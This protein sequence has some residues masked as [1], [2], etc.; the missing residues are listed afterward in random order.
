MRR[1]RCFPDSI[2]KQ[3]I[4]EDDDGTSTTAVIPAKAGIQ[5][6]ASSRFHRRRL[7]I[8]DR[9]LSRTM[10]NACILATAFARVLQ[11]YSPQKRGRSATLKGGRRE[12]RVR[13]APAVSCA[14]RRIKKRTRAYRFSG[15][16]PAFPAR[17]F[18][19]YIVL[20][21]ARPGLFVT[22]IP[23]KRELPRNL[24]PAIGASGPHDFTVRKSCA[25]QSQLKRP[26]HPTARF[27]TCATPLSSGGMRIVSR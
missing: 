7:G 11:N 13:A 25:R 17:W 5:Y 18:T 15:G 16:N 12:D 8:L 22:V 4:N 6:A 27:V 23:R 10:T 20:S 24:T 26:P 9:P 3:P 2:V 19:A 1:T 14:N 21:P